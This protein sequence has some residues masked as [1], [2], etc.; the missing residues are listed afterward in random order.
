VVTTNQ[1]DEIQDVLTDL[2][3]IHRGRIVF[4]CSMEAF[5]ARFWEVKVH[6]EGTAAARALKPIHER[7]ALGRSI[8]LFDGTDREQLAKLGDVRRPSVADVFLAV[9]G[10]DSEGARK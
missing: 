3:F 5:D 6:A 9:I 1:V 10:N 2:M 8:L 7:Q 4:E